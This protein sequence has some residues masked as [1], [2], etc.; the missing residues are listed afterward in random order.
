LSS[1]VLTEVEAR[2]DRILILSQGRL[3]AEGTLAELRR[4]AALPV[5]LT[6]VPA[7]GAAQALAA[8][9]PQAR[10]AGDGTLHLAC[11]QDEK[12]GLLA[13]IAG[14]GGQVADLDVIPP[15]LEDIYSHFSRRDGQ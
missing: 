8:A 9:L 2:T 12:L 15:S 1:H 6:V 4:R 14:L 13:R 11:A 10:L 5:G 7:P 3:V